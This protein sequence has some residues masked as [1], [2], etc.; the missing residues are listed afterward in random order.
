MAHLYKLGLENF[1]VF[2]DFTEIE[3]APITIF[4][5]TN[6]S[7]KS[8]VV[9]AI[10]LLRNNLINLSS[11]SDLTLSFIS[12][13]HKLSSFKDIVNDP[14]KPLKFI[15]PT[16]LYGNDEILTL[17]LTYIMNKSNELGEGIINCIELYCEK[18]KL[19]FKYDIINSKPN[20]FTDYKY[21]YD[22]IP[23]LINNLPYYNSIK[24]KESERKI[25]FYPYPL[26]IKPTKEV[27]GG[28]KSS[29]QKTTKP[30][31][32]KSG[33]LDPQLFLFMLIASGKINLTLWIENY[34][35]LYFAESDKEKVIYSYL[36]L[37]ANISQKEIVKLKKQLEKQ[38]LDYLTT[39]EV[40]EFEG[41][42][43]WNMYIGGFYPNIL[44]IEWHFIEEIFKVIP[45]EKRENILWGIYPK[46]YN[47]TLERNLTFFLQDYISEN[48]SK[49]LENAG[50][51]F[52]K[53]SKLDSV[54]AN[55]Q[56]LY[57]YT[58]QGTEFN[59]LL[60]KAL[61]SNLKNWPDQRGFLNKWLNKFGIKG[62]LEISNSLPGVGI[63]V[64]IGGRPLADL[65]YGITQ[66][67]PILLEII[68]T[69]SQNH[70]DTFITDADDGFLF[71]S[72]L[73]IEE[74]ETNL[75]PRYQSM[76]ADLFVAA[77]MK[78][79]IQFIIETH[80]E[81]LIRKI[82]YLTG[83]GDLTPADT[84]LY[85]FYH[86]DEIPKGEKQVK[87]I[88]IGQ[89]GRLSDYFGEGFFDEADNLAIQLFVLN[90]TA[91]N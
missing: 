30:G 4:T 28:V 52:R 47:P 55:T 77:S 5:G 11:Y 79:K 48:M 89:D 6:N 80:S 83:K 14:S 87:K 60:L 27:L 16:V 86:P 33:L 22:K 71:N 32:N 74:P 23:D 31:F 18:K 85:Y 9:K 72:T 15:L 25:N 66:L 64:S 44:K 62:E 21:F 82:Q 75:H 34:S 42:P 91:S 53:I 51:Y 1:R 12:G 76:L 13:E 81:Y 90:K 78:Y 19:I 3:F 39:I 63:T 37:V 59:S 73:I 29:D 84:S 38:L 17:C 8:S 54:R 56:R 69:G 20:V 58:S 68:L 61:K 24:L 88:E 40:A 7:G 43:F 49:I 50:K 45:V 70:S 36:E 2:K 35:N 57:T 67:V 65:G 10:Q 41:S 46:D 26:L